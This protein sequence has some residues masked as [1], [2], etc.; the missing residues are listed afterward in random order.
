LG[1]GTILNEA[2]KAQ[3]ILAE[4]YNVHADV[5]SATSYKNLYLEVKN[6]HRKRRGILEVFVN[7]L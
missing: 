6:P 1:S 3:E 2:D 4:K 7:N 5:W